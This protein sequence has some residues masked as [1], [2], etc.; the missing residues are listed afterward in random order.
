MSDRDLAKERTALNVERRARFA[1]DGQ[2][3][4]DEYKAKRRAAYEN[5]D[6]L[7]A[8]R[9]ARDAAATAVGKEVATK[10]GRRKVVVALI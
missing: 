5:A 8:L 10:A 4:M 6:R 1:Q 2:T 7:T 3:A 9:Q